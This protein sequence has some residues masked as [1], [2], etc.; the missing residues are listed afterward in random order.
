MSD[1]M[2]EMSNFIGNLKEITREEAFDGELV[3]SMERPYASRILDFTERLG[4]KLLI[5][6][7]DH[8]GTALTYIAQGDIISDPFCISNPSEVDGILKM[9]DLMCDIQDIPQAKE[10]FERL[11]TRVAELERLIKTCQRK[12]PSSDAGWEEL[13]LSEWEKLDTSASDTTKQHF[14]SLF[15]RAKKIGC[16]IVC[17][18]VANYYIGGR[19]PSV[20]NCYYE[21]P[22]HI[23]GQNYGCCYL[24]VENAFDKRRGHRRNS[25]EEKFVWAFNMPFEID[26]LERFIAHDEELYL[27]N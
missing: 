11:E 12:E 4:M 23:F 7:Y 16:N 18:D 3:D 6:A 15:V 5:D 8:T 25:R 20:I 26:E 21:R 22:Y 24:R 14:C 1:R 27:C 10:R 19:R 2:S 13:A 17:G 9:L